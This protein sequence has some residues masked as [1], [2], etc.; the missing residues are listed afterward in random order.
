MSY[1]SSLSWLFSFHF[2]FLSFFAVFCFQL[3][4]VCKTLNINERTEKIPATKREKVARALKKTEIE[5][6]ER[7]IA[8]FRKNEM[9]YCQR[10]IKWYNLTGGSRRDTF[11]LF[12]IC[13]CPLPMRKYNSKCIYLPTARL[14]KQN[15]FVKRTQ[16]K[17][18]SVYICLSM[19]F[20]ILFFRSFFCNSF[21]VLCD[22]RLHFATKYTETENDYLLCKRWASW[23][24]KTGVEKY[25]KL[26]IHHHEVNKDCT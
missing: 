15:S 1:F 3:H 22:I 4:F 23:W 11:T 14:Y 20:R 16:T 12:V 7:K 18:N 10:D 9:R 8:I 24:R 19:F 26:R 2:S 6:S 25:A 13:L 17:S 21:L 5:R